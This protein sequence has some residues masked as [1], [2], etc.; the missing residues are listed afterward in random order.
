M[1]KIAIVGCGWFGLPLAKQLV[2]DGY[3]VA[4]TKTTA[5][6]CDE[7]SQYG[8]TAYQLNLSQLND[9]VIEQ[10]SERLSSL[11]EADALIVNI[12]PGLRRGESQYL[13]HIERLKNLIGNRQYQRVIFISTTGVYPS[14][15]K[16]MN[17]ADAQSY[18]D[19][20]KI[21]L[22]AESYFAAMEN[23]CIIRFSGLIGPKRHPGKFFA[24]RQDIAGGN[25]A[26]NL[27]HLDDCIQAVSV[28]F[29]ATA[30]GKK[31]ASIYNLAAPKHPTRAEFY[32]QA[33][34]HLSLDEP[35][36]NQQIMPS[37]TIIG[38]LICQQLGFNYIHPDP[39]SMLDAC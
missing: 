28:I 22:E 2:S 38:D 6:G 39:V 19:K 23:A 32:R 20:S 33:A 17:E 9:E 4:G 12:P 3:Q 10:E 11:F 31:L 25:V 24:G 8:I 18:D 37:K 15:D 13:N 29:A 36:F 16:D 21:L 26:V 30:K 14:T 5:Q 1:N 7:L 27:V 34:L 35:E